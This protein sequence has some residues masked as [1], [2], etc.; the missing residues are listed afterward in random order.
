MNKVKLEV[1]DEQ[2]DIIDIDVVKETSQ[3]R[4]RIANLGNI[5]PWDISHG[6]RDLQKILN[7][8]WFFDQKDTAIFGPKTQEALTNYQLQK[9]V[10]SD[11]SIY[12]AWLLWPK[13]KAQLIKDL[14]EI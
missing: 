11:T 7:E 3:A 13:T 10:I 14:S 4:T 5:K 9:K 8:L 1:E 6:V 12:W 2:E